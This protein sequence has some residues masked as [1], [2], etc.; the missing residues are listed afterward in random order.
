MFYR[1]L[2]AFKYNTYGRK[3][4]IEAIPGHVIDVRLEKE[5]NALLASGRIC[6]VD[7]PPLIKEVPYDCAPPRQP[8]LRIGLFLF[9][10]QHYS[11]GRI[12]LYQYAHCLASNGA[13][14]YYYSNAIPRWRSDYPEIS[15][16]K[17]ILFGQNAPPKDLDIVM[18]D[19]KGVGGAN[20]WQYKKAHPNVKLC[21]MNFETPN[22][23]ATIL[24]QLAKK[25]ASGNKETMRAADMLFANSRLS[26]KYV[27]EWIKQQRNVTVLPPAVNTHV[28][29][30]IKDRIY[31]ASRK[32]VVWSGR[33][34]SYKGGSSAIDFVFSL[35]QQLDIVTFGTQVSGKRSNAKHKLVSL[36]Q[37]SDAEKFAMMRHANAVLAPS[38]FEGFGMVPAEALSVGTP[39]VAYDLPVLR[40]EYG[41]VGGLHLV[42]WNDRKAFATKAIE[43]I[44]A[45]KHTIDVNTI[46]KRFGIGAMRARLDCTPHHSTRKMTV[47]AQMIAYWGFIPETV[48]AIYDHVD[49]IV[50][51][52]GKTQNA[53]SIDDGSLRRIQE[54]P[55]P[56]DKIVLEIRSLWKDKREMRNWC[57]SRTTS[58]HVLVLDGDEIWVG[59]DTWKRA[60]I[61][62]GSPRWV[63]LWHDDAHHVV[64]LPEWGITRWGKEVKPYGCLCNH[65][66]WSWFRP[67][68]RWGIHCRMDTA[69]G[70]PIRNGSPEIALKAPECVIYHLGHVLPANVMKAKHEFYKTRDGNDAARKARQ[71][72]WHRW[73][74]KLGNC[75]DGIVRAID[76]NIPDIVRR[77]VASAKRI[78][79]HT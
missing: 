61:H 48:E 25:I 39:V 1:V 63:T 40:E 45:K 18:T 22:W 73:N 23:V 62:F 75:G 41:E 19:G 55:D 35:D 10:S 76:W 49:Q 65:Y 43:V 37:R 17:F 29:D 8:T 7:L 67:S 34:Q 53:R 27:Q 36:N 2:K 74:G 66:R 70:K 42:K 38:L 13:E 50:I 57:S 78:E 32:Y 58:N 33:G 28:I 15:R 60:N 14:V 79:V 52:F 72:A 77:G 4:I 30:S 5:A 56:D 44:N 26:A 69:D 21:V 6:P 54:L 3:G 12:H 68:Y 20:A 47:T 59:L 11:G 31:D 16:M 46:R 9:T 51:A 71:N 24:P 64:G